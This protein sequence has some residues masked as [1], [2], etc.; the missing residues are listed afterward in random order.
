[1]PTEAMRTG[2]IRAGPLEEGSGRRLGSGIDTVVGNTEQQGEN[3]QRPGRE[4]EPACS[5]RRKL[6]WEVTRNKVGQ[7]A[8]VSK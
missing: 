8:G 7:G 6:H 1:M 4:P 2:A 5:S 3:R